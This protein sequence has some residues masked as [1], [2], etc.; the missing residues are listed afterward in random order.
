MSKFV[1]TAVA[2]SKE[3]TAKEQAEKA[4]PVLKAMIEAKAKAQEA[5]IIGL[6]ASLTEADASVEKA[7]GTVTTDAD[8]YLETVFA[9]MTSRDN[10]AEDLKVAE[11]TLD[12]INDTLKVFVD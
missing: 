2:N 7:Q 3:K 12:E 5:K 4:Q 6:K 9:R 11:T 10:V 8:Y 1:E